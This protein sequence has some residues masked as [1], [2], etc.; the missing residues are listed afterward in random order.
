MRGPALERSRAGLGLMAGALIVLC[1]VAH[2]RAWRQQE[3]R[4]DAAGV[5][6]TIA[7]DYALIWHFGGGAILLF[8]LISV[9]LFTARLRGGRPPG[10]PVLLIA[11][12]YVLFGAVATAVKGPIPFVPAFLIPGLMLLVAAAPLPHQAVS[13]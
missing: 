1:S 5:S 9:W 4:L 11:T 10:T 2:T 3:L 13:R 7:F 6:D 12:G 8:G